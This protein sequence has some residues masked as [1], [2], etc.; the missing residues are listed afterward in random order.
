MAFGAVLRKAYNT[1]RLHMFLTDQIFRAIERATV[2]HHGQTRRVTGVPYIVHP[3]AVGF[4][5]AHFT[6]NEDVII[7]GLLHDTLEDVPDY[8][9]EMLEVEF[10]PEVMRLVSEVTEDNAIYEEHPELSHQDR[11]RLKKQDYLE[12]LMDDSE[13][14][15][16]IAAADKICNTRS[17]LGEYKK[18]GSEEFWKKWRR[19]APTFERG[20]GS[21]ERYLHFALAFNAIIQSKL[22]HPL[23][24]ELDRVTKAAEKVI[25]ETEK[26]L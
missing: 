25:R 18:F 23:A 13:G 20:R 15:L 11:V 22:K 21:S 3:Y 6:D 17:F 2:L 12:R 7:A 5:L 24:E 14:A 26:A 10:G 9:Q 4:L 1:S 16:M 8:T 19:D